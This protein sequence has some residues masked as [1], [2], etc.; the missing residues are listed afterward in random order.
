MIQLGSPSAAVRGK[1]FAHKLHDMVQ[2][3]VDAAALRQVMGRTRD[4]S[5]LYTWYRSLASAM[6]SAMA[7]GKD[8]LSHDVFKRVNTEMLPRLDFLDTDRG[9]KMSDEERVE[10]VVSTKL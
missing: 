10:E 9:K 8:A 2:W 4:K 1:A 7:S 3:D 6:A 5:L